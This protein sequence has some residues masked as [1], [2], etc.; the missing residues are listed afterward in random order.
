MFLQGWFGRA[1]TSSAVICLDSDDVEEFLVEEGI[2]HF[3][4]SGNFEYG[5]SADFEDAGWV[6]VGPVKR[7]AER[8][9]NIAP[10]NQQTKEKA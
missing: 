4:R 5:P 2:G 9:R 3:N 7:D 10:S 6:D 1:A 8:R